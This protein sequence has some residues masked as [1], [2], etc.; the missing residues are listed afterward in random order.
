MMRL[1]IDS[2]ELEV[3]YSSLT[4]NKL[5]LPTECDVMSNEQNGYVPPNQGAGQYDNQF[6]PKDQEQ[7]KG[8]SAYPR[9]GGEPGADFSSS[10]HAFDPY[11]GER[12]NTMQ[13]GQMPQYGEPQYDATQ[14]FDVAQQYAQPG[15]DATQAYDMSQYAQHQFEAPQQVDVTPQYAATQQFAPVQTENYAYPPQNWQPTYAQTSHQADVF[16]E[17]STDDDEEPN[18][19]V[20]SILIGLIVVLLVAAA[21]IGGYFFMSRWSDDSKPSSQQYSTQSSKSSKKSEK[22]KASD[23]PTPEKTEETQPTPEPTNR[24]LTESQK[25]VAVDKFSRYASNCL[26]D[27]HFAPAGCTRTLFMEDPGHPITKIR[28]TIIEQPK[29]VFRH[30][31]SGTIMELSGGTLRIEYEERWSGNEPWRAGNPIYRYDVFN[32]VTIPVTD[33]GNDVVLDFSNL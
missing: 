6:F 11:T 22:D 3:N 20:R 24:P 2:I 33:T 31:N 8:E 16:D 32:G 14:Q 13:G 30:T 21:G 9:T 27:P 5:R 19:T 28:R 15:F 25:Q 4:D 12:V 17:L 1:C 18:N 29:V 23:K 26:N 10:Q 7:Y